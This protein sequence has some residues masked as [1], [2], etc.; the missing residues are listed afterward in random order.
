[1][2]E[3]KRSSVTFVLKDVRGTMIEDRVRLVFR[4]LAAQS[5]GLEASVDFR[6]KSVVNK[7]NSPDQSE[8]GQSNKSLQ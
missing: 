7:A 2:D 1:M 6:G 4:N 3:S 5:R 8:S